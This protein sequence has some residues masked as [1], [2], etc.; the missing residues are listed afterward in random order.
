[1]LDSSWDEPIHE[2]DERIH[3]SLDRSWALRKLRQREEEENKKEAHRYL[4]LSFVQAHYPSLMPLAEECRYVITSNE[5]L[6]PLVRKVMLA[7][8]EDEARL[9]LHTTLTQCGANLFKAHY[10]FER[11]QGRAK[12]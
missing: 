5:I 11:F 4:L 1:M 6:Q 3:A 2:F 12:S 7:Q 9:H 10:L 8:S